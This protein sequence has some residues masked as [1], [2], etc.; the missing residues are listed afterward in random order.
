MLGICRTNI[1]A[2][3]RTVALHAA[4]K[5]LMIRLKRACRETKSIERNGNIRN[6][7]ARSKLLLLINSLFF[8][9]VEDR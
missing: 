8:Y 1:A 6:G 5:R 9:S 4:C 3:A 2:A 7:Q